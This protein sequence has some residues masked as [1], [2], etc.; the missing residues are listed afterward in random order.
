MLGTESRSLERHAHNPQRAIRAPDHWPLHRRWV[1]NRTADATLIRPEMLRSVRQID[2]LGLENPSISVPIGRSISRAELPS[3]TQNW[4][5][6]TDVCSRLAMARRAKAR[7]ERL[8]VTVQGTLIGPRRRYLVNESQKAEIAECIR[9]T[10]R[11]IK[12]FVF[13]AAILIPLVLIGS[14]FWFATS[15][16]TLSVTI[17]DASGQTTSQQWVGPHGATGTLAGAAGSRTIFTVSGP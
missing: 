6:C 7:A 2:S 1:A 11:R 13:S 4:Q 16:A 14:I 12:P 9:Q 17:V 15:G 10:L 3:T 8:R 5:H